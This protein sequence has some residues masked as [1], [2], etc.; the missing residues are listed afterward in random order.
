M[1]QLN[2]SIFDRAPGNRYLLKEGRETTQEIAESKRSPGA[3]MVAAKNKAGGTY[4]WLVYNFAVGSAELKPAHKNFL[5]QIST[6]IASYGKLYRKT[7]TILVT[8]FASPSGVHRDNITLAQKRASNVTDELVRNGISRSWCF[9]KDASSTDIYAVVKGTPV[10]PQQRNLC[11]GVYVVLWLM[12][13]IPTPDKFS[14][15]LR[16]R[17]RSQI[18]SRSSG[19]SS[20]DKELQERFYYWVIDNWAYLLK[21]ESS[22]V[23]LSMPLE[24]GLFFKEPTTPLTNDQDVWTYLRGL[25]DE[26]LQAAYRLKHQYTGVPGSALP[27]GG[28][29][30]RC[31]QQLA[32]WIALDDLARSGSVRVS[33]FMA[34]QAVK[35]SMNELIGMIN[36]KKFGDPN[37]VWAKIE[38][39]M[40]EKRIP[41]KVVRKPV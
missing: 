5:T 25:H 8:G 31:Y 41:M 9:I 40:N 13:D 34:M 33:D 7:G 27:A 38:R 16:Q 10:T 28:D 19:R 3:G 24:N 32:R 26:Y 22:Y 23:R 30:V 20:R 37:A 1:G 35:T 12:R 18:P 2:P 4:A 6:E 17:A 11:R 29:P 14:D 39:Y 21:P 15:E 36:N